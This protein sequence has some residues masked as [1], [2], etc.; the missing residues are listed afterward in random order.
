MAGESWRR[1]RQ[2]HVPGFCPDACGE[3]KDWNGTGVEAYWNARVAKN[4]SDLGNCETDVEKM[5]QFLRMRSDPDGEPVSQRLGDPCPR[6]DGWFSLDFLETTAVVKANLENLGWTR[7]WHGTKIE[8]L[9]SILYHGRLFESRDSERG[10]RM[11]TDSPGVYVHKDGTSHKA[12]NYLRFVQLF[13]DGVFW[14]AKWEVRVHRADRVIV[15]HQ[16]DQWVQRARSVRL[17]ALWL[18]AR[19][20]CEMHAGDAYSLEWSPMREANPRS[21]CWQFRT[22]LEQQANQTED[23]GASD[24]VHRRTETCVSHADPCAEPVKPVSTAVSS[25][26]TQALSSKNSWKRWMS[27]PS[28]KLAAALHQFIG[29]DDYPCAICR[30]PMVSVPSHLCSQRHYSSLWATLPEPHPPEHC[31]GGLGDDGGLWAQSFAAAGAVVRFNHLTGESRVEERERPDVPGEA[32]GSPEEPDL[33]MVGFD[34]ARHVYGRMCLLRVREVVEAGV[35]LDPMISCRSIHGFELTGGGLVEP[36]IGENTEGQTVAA[37]ADL[38]TVCS[39]S[40]KTHIFVPCGHV[41][42]CTACAKSFLQQRTLCPV[43]QAPYSQV[44]QAV[45]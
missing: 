2:V 23:N 38:C 33:L 15:P 30:R 41:C 26:Y 21:S 31:V 42:A 43:C 19:R 1:G 13:G 9:Y 40:K 34:E 5:V 18:C 39:Q 4:F 36:V 11:L 14:A 16:T 35:N 12:E 17:V 45:F 44:I 20:A 6:G 29:D 22:Q 32:A 28:E 25:C 37:D 24:L 7:A 10:D 3:P 8:C 27:E